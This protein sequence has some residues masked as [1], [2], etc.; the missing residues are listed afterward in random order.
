MIKLKKEEETGKI[1]IEKE[2]PYMYVIFYDNNKD[3]I[4]GLG[5]T[6]I[7]RVNEHITFDDNIEYIVRVVMHD[8][9]KNCVHVWLRKATSNDVTLMNI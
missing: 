7:P 3:V 9:E 5:L 6:V 1:F 4:K 8:Y 2:R